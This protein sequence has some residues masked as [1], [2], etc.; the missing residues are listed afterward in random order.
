MASTYAELIVPLTKDEQL[1]VLLALAVEEELPTTAWDSVAFPRAELEIQSQ[2]ESDLTVLLA[3]L[4]MGGVLD[5]ATGKWLTILAKSFYGLDR[6]PSRTCRGQAT[7]YCASNAGPYTITPGQLWASD[8]AAGHRFNCI[9]TTNQTL[10]AGG[11][12]TLDWQA[13]KGGTGYSISPL[14]LNQLNTPLVGVTISNPAL[15]G[16]STW[17]TRAG[18]EEENDAQL[19]KRCR[20][21]W[22]AMTGTTA[23]AYEQW[24]LDAPTDGAV[25]RSKALTVSGGIVA[26]YL[27]GGDGGVDAAAVT[28]VSDYI[29]VGPP[30]RLPLCATLNAQSAIANVV[31]IVG[32]ALVDTDYASTFAAAAEYAIRRYLSTVDIGDTIY[33]AQLIEIIMALPGAKNVVLSLPAA[34]IVQ[35]STQVAALGTFSLQV[36]PA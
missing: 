30:V 19:R 10:V 36:T 20:N 24:A 4:A 27:A 13:E 23:A 28:A 15:A 2:V 33:L 14:A 6:Y 3:A 22:P 29:Q 7:L 25:N 9:N 12:L 11:T 31:N 34:D 8:G 1:A 26:L 35:T 5:D 32:A 18:T 21:R 16:S 17:I